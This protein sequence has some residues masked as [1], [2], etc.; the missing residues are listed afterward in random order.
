MDR[1]LPIVSI[2]VPF[3]SIVVPF[4]G[5]IPGRDG[6]QDSDLVGLFAEYRNP[7][8]ELLRNYNGDYRL[9]VN[10]EWTDFE[11]TPAGC[12]DLEDEAFPLQPDFN[13]HS[14][15][16]VVVTSP[17][18]DSWRLL[19]ACRG[20]RYTGDD[21]L[22][23]KGYLQEALRCLIEDPLAMTSRALVK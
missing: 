1:A 12:L 16:N 15:M 17:T 4:W 11:D 19:L 3:F 8:K 5:V 2:V 13:V 20:D 10:F 9:K 21:Q 23:M 7:K 22:R 18:R 14:P 6:P